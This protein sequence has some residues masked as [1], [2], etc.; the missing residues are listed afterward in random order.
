MRVALLEA[1]MPEELAA[2]VRRHGGEPCSV[3]AVREGRVAGTAA[4]RDLLE[5]A[6][7]EAA[8][9]LVFS[10]GVGVAA[11]F[12]ECRALG[13]EG[14][15][16]EVLR[17]ATIVCRG[18]KPVAALRREGVD[19]PV[20][21]RAPYTT[22]ELLEALALL[23]VEGHLAV[24]VHYGE[25]NTPLVDAVAARGARVHELLLYAWH[26]PED[27]EPLRRLV[28]EIVDGQ[29]GAVV[30]TSQIQARHLFH[31]AASME[32]EGALRDALRSRTVVAAVGPTCARALAALGVPPHVVPDNPKMGAMLTALADHMGKRPPQ[33]SQQ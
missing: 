14:D 15:L 11:L 16:R 24:I 29:V 7:H 25:R 1:R 8:P 13:R 23:G 9:V 4:V 27:L 22:A 12:A 10:S 28:A 3:P 2:L 18:P 26:L 30:F 6:G 21:V 31:V 5:R 19:A 33:R 32:R 20:R 17:C